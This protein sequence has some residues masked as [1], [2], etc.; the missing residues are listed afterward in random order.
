MS[1]ADVVV[2]G[3]GAV[4]AAVAWSLAREGVGV[5]LLEREDLAG[6]A[7]GAAAGMLAPLSEAAQSGSGP[8]APAVR[9]LLAWGARSLDLY[10]GLCAELAAQTG[11]DPELEPSGLLRVARDADEAQR[12]RSLVE[13]L[14]AWQLAWL[15][16]ESARELEP[17]LAPGAPGALHSPREGHVRSPLL[18]R[19]YAE[20]ARRSGAD[21]RTGAPVQGL[22]WRGDRVAGVRRPD[23]ELAAGRVVVCTGAAAAELGAWLGGAWTPR[24][25]PVRGQICS[26]DAPRPAPRHILWRGPLYAVPKRDGSVV[27][28]ATEERVGF[29]RR[30]TA[31]GMAGLLS[32]APA[33]APGLADAGFRSG[34]AGLRP[35]SPDGLPLVGAVPGARD[36]W[37][38]AGHHRNGVLL[39]AVTGRLVSDALLGKELPPEAAAFDPRRFDAR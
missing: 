17:A 33:L 9:A 1:A 18:T 39:S 26:L 21:V 38:A 35:A 36:L 25:E 4:G 20:A 28:G 5:V 12:L 37:I 29:D 19:A 14:P 7:S 2:V 8:E 34:W 23:G 3:G 11:V 22:L 16:G 15:D 30:V 13:R 6:G 31:S 24:V 10:P 27:L 32:A